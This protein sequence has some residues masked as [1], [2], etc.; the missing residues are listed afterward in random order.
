MTPLQSA[1]YNM[2]RNFGD[3]RMS[4]DLISMLSHG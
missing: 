4:D 2:L 3:V 1:L